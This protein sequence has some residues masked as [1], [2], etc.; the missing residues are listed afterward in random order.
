[1]LTETVKACSHCKLEKPITEFYKNSVHG[2]ESWCKDCKKEQERTYSR[3]GGRAEVRKRLASQAGISY[4]N[5]RASK[6]NLSVSGE[7]LKEMFDA[8]PYCFYC[9]VSL[10]AHNAHIEHRVPRSKGGSD[11]ADN[12]VIACSDCNRIKHTRTEDEFRRFIIDY[13]HRFIA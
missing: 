13:C 2:N 10:E 11:D 12:L 4:W 7:A 5:N 1:M 9:R 6:N 3:N 8:D